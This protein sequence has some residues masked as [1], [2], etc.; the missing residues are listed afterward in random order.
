MRIITVPLCCG[1][2]SPRKFGFFLLDM[3]VWWCCLMQ[4]PILVF[5][6]MGWLRFFPSGF[7]HLCGLWGFFV[8][9][10][11][12]VWFEILVLRWGG[13]WSLWFSGLFALLLF[14]WP[15]WD[16]KVSLALISKTWF[17]SNFVY[18]FQTCLDLSFI[19]LFFE[20]MLLD[21]LETDI[22]M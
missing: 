16:L 19:V 5:W 18:D 1:L 12:G 7:S 17:C 14:F 20:L 9:E 11:G 22:D 13:F 4:N 21:S 2:W 3:L 15:F 8:Y 6:Y 10:G